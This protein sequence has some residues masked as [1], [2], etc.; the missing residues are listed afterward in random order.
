MNRASAAPTASGVAASSVDAARRA[1]A[2]RALATLLLAA[3]VAALAVVTDRLVDTWADGHLFA[4]WVLMWAVVF[5]GSV[6]LAS[7][8]RHAAH[9]LIMALNAWARRRAQARAEAR[10]EALARADARI[11]AEIEAARRHAEAQAQAWA[12]A[13]EPLG[14]DWLGTEDGRLREQVADVADTAVNFPRDQ[15]YTLYY[16]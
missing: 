4:A 14:P 11:R 2:P 12:R 5:L 13:L 16:I 1:V 6:V 9:R 8:A 7:P 10:M 3:G 15:R